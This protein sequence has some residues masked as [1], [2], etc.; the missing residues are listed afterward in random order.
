M[1]AVGIGGL[2]ACFGREWGGSNCQQAYRLSPLTL[3]PSSFLP[4]LTGLLYT[5]APRGEV[6]GTAEFIDTR[7]GLRAVVEFGRVEGSHSAVL[8]RPDALQ[9][10]IYRQLPRQGAAAAGL[11]RQDS[12]NSSASWQMPKGVEQ[13]SAG[14]AWLCE[15]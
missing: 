7:N 8:Q 13:V 14:R 5:A 4:C 15:P 2:A 1:G 10:A 12:V 3:P 6:A 11:S 9:G